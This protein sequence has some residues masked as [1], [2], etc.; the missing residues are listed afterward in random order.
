[1]AQAYDPEP[2][3]ARGGEASGFVLMGLSGL[4]IHARLHRQAG[5]RQ[6]Y[7]GCYDG[8]EMTGSFA[9]L[10][11]ALFHHIDVTVRLLRGKAVAPPATT[12]CG[13]WAPD[14]HVEP[15]AEAARTLHWAF[16]AGWAKVGEERMA[17]GPWK[18]YQHA[19]DWARAV[20]VFMTLWAL[21]CKRDGGRAPAGLTFWPKVDAAWFAD[22]VLRSSPVDGSRIVPADAFKA[23]E[24]PF[25]LP[26]VAMERVLGQGPGRHR[27]RA[28]WSCREGLARRGR[29]R[30][31]P[32]RRGQIG[33]GPPRG[34]A[35]PGGCPY[36]P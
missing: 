30:R 29:A 25:W 22:C 15:L 19:Y 13:R 8:D 26:F 10:A 21:G 20:Y 5:E 17:E 6:F 28:A 36:G 18:G 9:S 23:N 32:A 24:P 11:A 3:A 35:T 31:G 2:D 14:A 16:T 12:E 4:E 1:M 33:G 27:R 7:F 34:G